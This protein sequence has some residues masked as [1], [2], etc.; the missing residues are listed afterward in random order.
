MRT[1]II[2]TDIITET[3]A[4][5]RRNS[6]W[7]GDHPLLQARM[8]EPNSPSHHQRVTTSDTDDIDPLVDQQ[9]GHTHADDT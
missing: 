6:L 7:S 2:M 4:S 1:R 5:C 3:P 8:P 9:V